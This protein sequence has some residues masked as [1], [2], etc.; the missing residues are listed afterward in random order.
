MHIK[1]IIA[2]H[3]YPPIVTKELFDQVQTIKACYNRKPTRKQGKFDVLYR[4]ILRCGACGCM[5]SGE[6]KQKK[7][8][9]VYHYYQCTEYFSKH[10]A[11]RL[12]EQEITRQFSDYFKQLQIPDEIAAAIQADLKKS[13]QGKKEYHNTMNAHLE[14]EYSKLQNRIE[15]MYDD[16]LDGSITD[17]QYQERLTRFRIE[18]KSVQEKLKNL[19]TADED[20]YTTVN[21]ILN[22]CRRIPQLF[23]SSKPEIKRR[24]IN[25]VLLN[26]TLNDTTVNAT[27]RKP[28]SFWAKGS[29]CPIW[30]ELLGESQSQEAPWVQLVARIY[31]RK[32]RRLE[33]S[34]D[35]PFNH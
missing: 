13:H 12:T 2:P 8:G 33:L 4:G 19:H 14:Q 11:K 29:S 31:M 23:E 20:Y 21:F 22:L 26:P 7:S 1:G 32:T 25:L 24:L 28:F 6:R 35:Q 5:I 3:R 15:K 17:H 16:K 9:K 34:V 30:G 18:Q 10:G 27:I